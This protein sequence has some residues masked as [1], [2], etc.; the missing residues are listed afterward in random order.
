MGNR[1]GLRRLADLWYE[2]ARAV[3]RAV[4]LALPGRPFNPASITPT[5]TGLLSSGASLQKNTFY[6]PFRNLQGVWCIYTY[7]LIEY[8]ARTRSALT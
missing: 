8:P 3:A 1:A 5:D 4:D 2:N 7:G 6:N